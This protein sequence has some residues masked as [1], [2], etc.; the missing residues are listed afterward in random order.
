M[1]TVIALLHERHLG[2]VKRIEMG[3][4]VEEVVGDGQVQGP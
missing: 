2:R 3:R 4:E 1:A